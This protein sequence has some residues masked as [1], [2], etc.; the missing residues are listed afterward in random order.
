M[1]TIFTHAAIPIAMTA[2]AGRHRIPLPITSAGC[3]LAM[4]PDFD[5]MAFRMGIP[6]EA[7]WGHRGA[8]HSIF[9]ALTVTLAVAAVWPKARRSIALLFLALSM[10]SHGLLDMLTDGGLGVSYLWPFSTHRFFAPWQ[11]IRV[12]PIGSGFFGWRGLETLKSEAMW[13]VVP[14]MVT[15]A[16]AVILRRGKS[17]PF[18]A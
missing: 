9:L 8:T 15:V 6:Y 7:D 14:C 17:R 11:P 10:A 2:A 5:V 18:N 3:L 4:L 1:P 12:S 13:V 16:I